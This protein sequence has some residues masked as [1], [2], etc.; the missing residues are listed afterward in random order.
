MELNVNVPVQDFHKKIPNMAHEVLTNVFRLAHVLLLC[1][2][3]YVIAG[4]LVYFFIIFCY[5]FCA[6][7]SLIILSVTNSFFSI[8]YL[9]YF[10]IFY[11]FH[12]AFNSFYLLANVLPI[13]KPPCWRVSFI[14]KFIMKYYRFFYYQVSLFSSILN[15][16]F[17]FVVSFQTGH[18]STVGSLAFREESECICCCAHVCW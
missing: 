10:N 16:Y 9:Y 13:Q 7:V 1:S 11:L 6:P 18:F 17:I 3:Q 8:C 12:W 2:Y 4:Q 15:F 5:N 14:K